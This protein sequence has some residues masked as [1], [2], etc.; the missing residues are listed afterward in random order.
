MSPAVAVLEDIVAGWLVELLRLPRGASVGF[1][2]GC[3]MANFTCLAAAR[4]E[5]AAARGV[6]RRDARPAA[7]ARGHRLRRRRGAHFGGGRPAAPRVR[8]R[9]ARAH[10]GGRSGTHERRCA[11]G[12]DGRGRGPAIVCAQAG[13][14]NT[15]ASD[16]IGRIVDIAHAHEA[17]VHVDGAFGLWA[18]AVP[19]LSDQVTGLDRADSWA[20]DAHKWLNVARDGAG[21]RRRPGAASGS[22]GPARVASPAWR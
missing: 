9:R 19:G 21:H 6:E 20:T 15:G 18:A 7:R 13:N 11:Q 8:H 17:W 16:P 3:H 12:R 10:R 22:D 5:G 14:V 1:V 2:S 4:H